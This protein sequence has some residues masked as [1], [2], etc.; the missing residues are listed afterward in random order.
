[1]ATTTMTITPAF[2]CPDLTATLLA[3]LTEGKPACELLLDASAMNLPTDW[4]Q[5]FGE[6]L[7]KAHVAM[8]ALEAGA[9]PIPMRGGWSATTGCVIPGGRRVAS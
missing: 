8:T 5:R 9:S 2:S 4:R 6:A 7:H 1:M 3:P